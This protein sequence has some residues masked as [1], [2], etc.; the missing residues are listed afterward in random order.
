MKKHDY[1]DADFAN[2]VN[3]NRTTVNRWRTGER[4]P[5][6]EKLPEIASIFDVPATIFIDTPNVTKSL[7]IQPVYSKLDSKHRKI[8]F[9]CALEQ[10]DDQ[11]SVSENY[12]IDDPALRSEQ[13]KFGDLNK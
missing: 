7:D 6:L 8:V 12:I 4:S 2:K 11:R 3:V 10:L 1:S 9:D 13:E 5:K